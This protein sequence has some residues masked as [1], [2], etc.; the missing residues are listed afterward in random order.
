VT[1]VITKSLANP[2]LLQHYSQYPIY[3]NSQDAP[4]PKNG[5]RKCIYTNGILLSHKE[6]L[7]FVTCKSI[8]GTREHHFK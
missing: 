5:S 4:Q 6:E 2:C 1:Q 7:N 3:G 8:D